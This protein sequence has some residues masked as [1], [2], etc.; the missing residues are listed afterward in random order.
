MPTFSSF[1]VFLLLCMSSLLVSGQE[2]QLP[3]SPTSTDPKPETSK[4][5]PPSTQQLAELTTQLNSDD[6]KTRE[7]AQIELTELALQHPEVALDP[8]LEN[9]IDAAT[10]PEARFRLRA[11]LYGTKQGEFMNTPR[12]FVG[13]VMNP[14]FARGPNGQMIH[15]IQIMRVV[16]GS[17]AEKFGLQLMD[18]IVGIDGKEFTSTEASTEF[19]TYV[20]AKASGEQVELK[21]LRNNQEMKI[22]LTLGQ[23]P[24]ELIDPRIQQQFEREFKLWLDQNTERLRAKK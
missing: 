16:P 6:F 14:A 2:N 17:A 5:P 10:V 20:T 13:I 3:A 12:G 9:Y 4:T 1:A 8:I 18:Q 7:T 21:V 23:R 19:S 11:I 22:P 15:A 24:Q